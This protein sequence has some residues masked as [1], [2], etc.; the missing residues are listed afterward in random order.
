MQFDVVGEDIFLQYPA[1]DVLLPRQS[2][3]PE[4]DEDVDFAFSDEFAEFIQLRSIDLGSGVF[5]AELVLDGKAVAL[6]VFPH[7]L[8]L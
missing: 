3:G 1:G 6:R 2:V 8:D 7:L 4:D 5:L